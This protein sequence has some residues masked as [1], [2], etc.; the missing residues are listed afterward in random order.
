MDATRQTPMKRYAMLGLLGVC[1][2]L[3]FVGLRGSAASKVIGLFQRLGASRSARPDD[4]SVSQ[5]LPVLVERHLQLMNQ[6][7]QA[8]QPI[9]SQAAKSAPSSEP[10]ANPLYTAQALRDPLESLF[11]PETQAVPVAGPPLPPIYQP[12]SYPPSLMVQGML[13]GADSPKAIINGQVCKVGDNVSG[14]TITSITRQ[15]IE[16]EFQGARYL[17]TAKG[18]TTMLSQGAQ[19]R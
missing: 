3:L 8:A 7:L 10:P 11:P 4:P 19:G 6:Q 12:P 17:T 1:V 16:V 15:G 18:T 14:A 5:P 2:V 9:S 13:W